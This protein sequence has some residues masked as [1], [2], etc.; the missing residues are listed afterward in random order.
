[1]K[2]EYKFIVY[3]FVAAFWKDSVVHRSGVGYPCIRGEPQSPV[4]FDIVEHQNKLYRIKST[5]VENHTSKY[6]E[7]Q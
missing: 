3:R 6:F 7:L 4:V 1:M 5:S 2:L